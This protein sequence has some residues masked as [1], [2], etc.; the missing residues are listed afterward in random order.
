MR[1]IVTRVRPKAAILTHFGFKMIQEGPD[2]IAARLS[3]ETGIKVIAAQ[4][5]MK[6]EF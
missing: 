4:D 6:W 5:G 1:T 2:L 3:D